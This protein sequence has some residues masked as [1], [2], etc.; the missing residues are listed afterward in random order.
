MENIVT[1]NFEVKPETMW[2]ELAKIAQKLAE[3]WFKGQTQNEYGGV[4]PLV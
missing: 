4:L 1:V 3:D 2:R